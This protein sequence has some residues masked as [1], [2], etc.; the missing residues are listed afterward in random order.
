MKKIST[1]AKEIE[2]IVNPQDVNNVVGYKRENLNKLEELY[3]VN[4]VV[5][6]D[7]KQKENN[8]DVN[9]ENLICHIYALYTFI[10]INWTFDCDG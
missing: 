8:I 7:I 5:R 3:E 10:N 4:I 2:I 9:K 1:K 6:Q